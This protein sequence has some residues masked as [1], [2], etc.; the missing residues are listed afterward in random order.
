MRTVIIL[1]GSDTWSFTVANSIR[2][3]LPHVGYL[4]ADRDYHVDGFDS[5]AVTAPEDLAWFALTGSVLHSLISKGRII[6]DFCGTSCLKDP[7]GFPFLLASLD[8]L[9]DT[10]PT[11]AIIVS[12]R[13]IELHEIPSNMT[14][15][16]N[17]YNVSPKVA[18][19]EA[20]EFLHQDS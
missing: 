4:H 10:V 8:R 16:S 11:E 9:N 6:A 1:I 13:K 17:I 12:D 3:R 19:A 5:K 2:R 20:V 14:F 7:A 15:K 18:A